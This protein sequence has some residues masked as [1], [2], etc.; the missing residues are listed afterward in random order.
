MI[1]IS[2]PKRFDALSRFEILDFLSNSADFEYILFLSYEFESS[3]Q[4]KKNWLCTNSSVPATDLAE[5][6]FYTVNKYIKQVMKLAIIAS[7]FIISGISAFT[8]SEDEAKSAIVSSRARRNVF[9]SSNEK[10]C[11]EK[12]CNWEKYLEGR[13]NVDNRRGIDLR[14]ELKVSKRNHKQ[15]HKDLFDQYY[16]NCWE[17]VKSVDL[18]KKPFNF[19]HDCF[20][21]HFALKRDEYY[22]NMNT[23][24]G[25]GTTSDYQ[26]Q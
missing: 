19:G 17:R 13:E 22:A 3:L 21:K 10:E 16:S 24:D 5:E 18:H 6:K 9:G 11:A 23:N 12:Q 1:K 20:H 26:Y 2:S 4:K 14:E 8:I 7:L 15:W 25:K